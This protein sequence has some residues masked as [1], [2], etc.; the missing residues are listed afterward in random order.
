MSGPTP[1]LEAA[2]NDSLGTVHYF[3]RGGFFSMAGTRR[4]LASVAPFMPQGGK[5]LDLGCGPSFRWRRLLEAYGVEWFG[6]DVLTPTEESPS[7]R[8]VVNNR[9]DFPDEYFDVVCAIDVFEHFT[10]PDAMVGEIA[11]VVKAG[12][13]LWGTSAFWQVEHDSCFHMTRLGLRAILERHGFELLELQPSRH[14]GFILIAQ[15]F[16]GGDGM[17]HL[18]T[19]RRALGSVA[20]CGLNVIPFGVCTVLEFARRRVR[21]ADPYADCASLSFI[22]R[23]I[24]PADRPVVGPAH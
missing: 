5:C 16:F 6:S 1:S 19:G 9:V 2:I 11:R 15:R 8:P 17:L 14:S 20:V 12:G 7:F 10:H 4:F 13:I 3:P 24:K 18:E 23:R 21:R 22:A